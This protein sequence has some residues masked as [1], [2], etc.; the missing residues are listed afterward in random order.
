MVVA[1][2]RSHVALIHAFTC[3]SFHSLAMI[4]RKFY[5]L[6]ILSLPQG[7]DNGRPAAE[8]QDDPGCYNIQAK[9]AKSV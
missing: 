5:K 8:H 7:Q 2:R 3:L 4:N 6:L 9:F 1:L